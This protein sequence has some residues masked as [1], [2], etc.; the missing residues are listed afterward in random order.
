ML[1]FIGS[2]F[3]DEENIIIAVF[4]ILLCF[5]RAAHSEAVAAQVVGEQFAQAWI[6]VHDEKVIA[7]DI[8]R[9]GQG[10][11][12]GRRFAKLQF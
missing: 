12:D 8:G 2:D 7:H 1:F 9:D 3:T 6:V 10:W 5:N 11:R 4:G